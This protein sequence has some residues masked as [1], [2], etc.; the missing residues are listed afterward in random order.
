VSAVTVLDEPIAGVQLASL[1]D[2][3]TTPEHSRIYR[4]GS[5]TRGYDYLIG[6]GDWMPRNLDR[7]VEAITPV[8][9]PGLQGRL[10]E[11]LQVNL[12]DD[13][14]AWELG[15]D[16]VWRRVEPSR[17]VDTHLTLHERARRRSER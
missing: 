16:S 12:A 14:L 15:A 7:R 3:T 10:E 11:I 8:R 4:F 13:L 9:D 2:A 5:E 1:R 6:S 17:G